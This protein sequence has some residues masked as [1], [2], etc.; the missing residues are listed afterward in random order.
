MLSTTLRDAHHVKWK[1]KTASFM[2]TRPPR[3]WKKQSTVI[4]EVLEI[5]R[6]KYQ[7]APTGLE[8]CGG[9]NAWT[10]FFKTR[11]AENIPMC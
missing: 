9:P 1:T 8:V 3:F 10:V 5:P 2:M 7:K 4:E 11:V 6:H